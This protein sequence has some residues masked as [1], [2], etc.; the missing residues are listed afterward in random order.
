MVTLKTT[1]GYEFIVDDDWAEDVAEV[2]WYCD[3]KTRYIYA[4]NFDL[5][6]RRSKQYLHRI[7]SGALISEVVDHADGNPLNNC[8]SN[9]RICTKKENCKNMSKHVDNTSGYKG[10]YKSHGTRWYAKIRSNGKTI[11]LGYFSNR[12]DAALAYNAGA[13]KYHGEFAKLNHL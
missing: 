1:N 6:K 9:L 4:R 3:K 5:D 10:V 13:I 8:R 12:E 7:I 11:N 2:K